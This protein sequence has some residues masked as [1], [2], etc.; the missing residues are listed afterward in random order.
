MT[1]VPVLHILSDVYKMWHIALSNI[2]RLSRYTLGAKIDLLF[3]DALELI[4][5]ASY[6]SR[7]KKLVFI[8]QASAKFDSLKF[9][10]Q[11]AWEMKFLDHKT[12]QLIATP[13]ID[14][15]KMLGSWMSS[16][17]MKAPDISEAS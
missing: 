8:Q 1:S 2:P 4:L 7:D 12:Y 17:K 11:L 5:L 16:L 9:F 14:V 13:L 3:C 15:G 10:L 6:T